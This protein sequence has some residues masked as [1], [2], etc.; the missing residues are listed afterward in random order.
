[1][2]AFMKKQVKTFDV[3]GNGFQK[4]TEMESYGNG[5]CRKHCC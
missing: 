5:V 3:S 4:L 1:M 2:G